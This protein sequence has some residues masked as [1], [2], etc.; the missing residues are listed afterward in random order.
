M[1]SLRMRQRGFTFVETLTALTVGG[2]ILTFVFPASMSVVHRTQVRRA[3]RVVATDLQHALSVAAGSRRPVRVEYHPGGVR[4]TIAR[5]ADGT[6]LRARE[7]GDVSPYG[8][9]SVSFTPAMVE[10]YPTGRVST[11]LVVTVER[12]GYARR[13]TLMR[14][15]MIHAVQP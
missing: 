10:V 14:S 1:R 9:S 6:I 15:G 8:L 3:V 11:E 12:G 5:A 4:Y 13:V 2:I 7:L